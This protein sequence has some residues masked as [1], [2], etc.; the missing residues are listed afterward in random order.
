MTRS[1]PILWLQWTAG[2]L[3]ACCGGTLCG[4]G[5]AAVADQPPVDGSTP[6]EVTIVG[7]P[8]L[9]PNAQDRPSPVVVRIFDLAETKTFDGADYDTLFEH[10]N[11]A[12]KH[13]VLAKDEFMLRPGDIQERNRS[14]PPAV[15][16][17][18]VA[19][20]FRDLEHAT[21]RMTIEVKPGRR[22]FLLIDLDRNTVRLVTV[23]A[24]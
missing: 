12:L 11:D 19:A 22:N 6:V 3:A 13:D 20:A 17:L 5:G 21:W 16:A 24:G 1:A 9:N 14:L 2:L 15:R 7:G 8:E 23:D 10:P 4:A 18:G